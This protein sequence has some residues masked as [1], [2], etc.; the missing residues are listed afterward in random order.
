MMPQGEKGEGTM[1]VVGIK[2][3]YIVVIFLAGVLGGLAPLRKK[4]LSGHGAG[5]GFQR[6]EAFA[7]GVFLG[8]GLLHLLPDAES[9]ITTLMPNQDF[10]LAPLFAG[11]GILAILLF[12]HASSKGSAHK[13]RTPILLMIM[14]SVHSII[15]GAALGIEG[16]MASSIA[17]FVAIMA[18]KSSAGFALGVALAKSDT[19]LSES[20]RQIYVFSLMTPIGVVLGSVMAEAFTGRSGVLFEALFDSVA[21]APFLYM[22]LG[23]I[24]PNAMQRDYGLTIQWIV[25]ILGFTTMAL[26]AIVA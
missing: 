26:I 3:A 13:D 14:L 19:A 9:N 24:L 21:A 15:A 5:V 23:S 8:A 18:H 20:K 2:V 17:L 22:S 1:E 11:I 6:G 10:P 12:D 4:S 25:A 7:G 16:G